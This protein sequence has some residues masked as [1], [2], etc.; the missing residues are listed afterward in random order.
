M[1]I[2]IRSEIQKKKIVESKLKTMDLSLYN[3]KQLEEFAQYVFNCG[4]SE[5]GSK[6]DTA[7]SQNIR[8]LQQI[9]CNPV[10]NSCKHMSEIMRKYF[11]G[12]H[13]RTYC[14]LF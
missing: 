3:E 1:F 10:K 2:C 11:F 6:L 12:F 7:V 14:K 5:I 13:P 9:S 8:K 4:W